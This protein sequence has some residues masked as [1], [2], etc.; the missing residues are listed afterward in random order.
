MIRMVKDDWSREDLFHSRGQENLM[1]YM[2]D[3]LLI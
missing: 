2:H 1:T 3:T